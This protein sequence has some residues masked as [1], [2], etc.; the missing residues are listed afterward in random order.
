M[1]ATLPVRRLSLPCLIS[2]VV[3]AIAVV[4]VAAPSATAA[5]AATAAASARPKAPKAAPPYAARVLKALQSELQRRRIP[6]A[7]VGVRTP[8]YGSWTAALGVADIAR[9]TPMTTATHLRIGSVTKT[10]TGTVVLQL[11]AEGK[12]SLD[13]PISRYVPDVPGGEAI[14]LRRLLDM[15]SGLFSYTEDDGFLER[16]GADGHGRRWTTDELLEIAFARDPYFAPGEGYHYSNTNTV[17]LGLAVEKVTGHPLRRELQRRIFG[18]LGM[19]GTV[20]P[21]D[22][23]R[24]AAPASRGYNFDAPGG[25]VE[26]DAAAVADWTAGTPEDLTKLDASWAWAAGG[27]VSTIGDLLRWATALGTGSLLDARMQRERLSWIPISSEPG[28]PKYGLAIAEFDGAIG[29]NGRLP[30]YTSFAVYDPR[31]KTSYAVIT[32]LSGSP[33][34]STPADVLVDVLRRTVGG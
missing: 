23:T 10:F 22:G 21:S 26:G 8:G 27:A 25:V 11:A 4:A 30:G 1:E 2:S 17:L 31:T 29:H 32:N 5:S 15:T 12:L 16:A 20:L 9:G 28:A 13:D 24:I 19:R 7:V 3:G 33:D 18:P 34:G 14:T 6:G